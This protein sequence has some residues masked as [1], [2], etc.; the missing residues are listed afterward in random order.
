MTSAWKTKSNQ[1][2]AAKSSGPKS[3]T[4]R[5]RAALNAVKHGLTAMTPVLDD[6]DPEAYAERRERLL[7][8][9]R[10]FDDVEGEAAESFVL[11]AWRR[12][13][14][15]RVETIHLQ[16]DPSSYCWRN[17]IYFDEETWLPV[18]T[19]C[20]D[21]PRPGTSDG[22]LLESFSYINIQTNVGLPDSFFN[23]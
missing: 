5:K 15:V 7:A 6:E 12:R 14:C 21:W 3:A 9:L 2:N 8:Q 11:A 19:E 13:R 4:G 10:P 16:P 1:R 22:D 17:V 23:K 20:Y 18:R